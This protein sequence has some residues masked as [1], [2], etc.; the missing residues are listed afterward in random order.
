VVYH[1]RGRYHVVTECDSQGAR[2]S[3]HEDDGVAVRRSRTARRRPATHHRAPKA[4]EEMTLQDPVPTIGD[5]TRPRS[6]T[7]RVSAMIRYSAHAGQS[8][9]T[10]LRDA[11]WAQKIWHHYY[12]R[13]HPFHETRQS[14]RKVGAGFT[15]IFALQAHRATMMKR[16][17]H[18]PG[19]PIGKVKKSYL[20][21]P[22]LNWVNGILQKVWWNFKHTV[23][24]TV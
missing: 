5:G 15:T 6:W 3:D 10:S 23:S 1:Y 20:R 22:K 14:S 4:L 9:S 18:V 7:T 11:K 16:G 17:E 13:S 19:T 2:T 12:T 8:D 24:C 21:G